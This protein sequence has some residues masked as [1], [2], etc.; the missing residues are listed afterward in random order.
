M[1]GWRPG[2]IES[3][4]QKFTANLFPA[5]GEVPVEQ[6]TGRLILQ[7]L[8]KIEAR[9]AIATAKRTLSSLGQ[10]MGYALASQYI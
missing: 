10:I 7:E 3:V 2:Y 5:F 9:V 6:M 8:C 4:R 1:N